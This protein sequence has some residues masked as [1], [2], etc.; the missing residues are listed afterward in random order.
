MKIFQ[1]IYNWIH[2]WSSPDWLQNWLDCLWVDIIVP[3]IHGVGAELV[4]TLQKLVIDASKL[5][6]KPEQRFIWVVNEFKST[7]GGEQ[8]KDHVLNLLIEFMV[9][10]LKTKT[11]I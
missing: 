10:Y 4:Q 8:I 11:M 9:T 1:K 3:L 2:G 7:W 6:L 5:D